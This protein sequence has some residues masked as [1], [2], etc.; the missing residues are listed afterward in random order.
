MCTALL[1][2][3]PQLPNDMKKLRLWKALRALH[4]VWSDMRSLISKEIVWE[5]PDERGQADAQDDARWIYMSHV[6]NRNRRRA[7]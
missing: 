1:G 4:S 2:L 7:R 3:C 5:D 6:L